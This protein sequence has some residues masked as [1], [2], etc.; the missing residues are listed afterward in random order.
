MIV[1][2]WFTHETP[3]NDEVFQR[4]IDIGCDVN[5][6]NYP[7]ELLKFLNKLKEKGESKK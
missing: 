4:L 5:I 3:E 7:L 2:F 6:T 1:K